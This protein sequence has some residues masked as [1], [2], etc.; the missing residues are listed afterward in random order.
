MATM[1]EQICEILGLHPRDWPPDYYSLL[2]LKRG[3]SDLQ[4]I[5]QRVHERMRQVRPYQLSYPDQVTDV[6]N[7]LAQAYGCLTDQAA[8]QAYDQ[9]LRA[10]RHSEPDLA[11][12]SPEN[13]LTDPDDPLAWL[14]G[15]WDRLAGAESAKAASGHRPHFQDWRVSPP[16][17]RQSDQSQAT[18]AREGERSIPSAPLPPSESGFP[19]LSFFWKHSELVLVILSLVALIV[20]VW[21]QLGP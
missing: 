8:R 4:L 20:A 11:Q 10:P 1:H 12:T 17:P 7:R 3:E 15:P 18:D 19:R 21:R 9:Y 5:E 2:G 14:F 13:G 6:L 16:P